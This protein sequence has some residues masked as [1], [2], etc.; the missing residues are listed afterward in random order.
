MP[1]P[2]LNMMGGIHLERQ[3]GLDLLLQHFGDGAVEVGEDLHGEL[4]IDAVLGDQIVEGV[5]ESGT[6]ATMSSLST[7]A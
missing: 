6:D 1:I 5:R 3:A 2:L 7:L 4:G